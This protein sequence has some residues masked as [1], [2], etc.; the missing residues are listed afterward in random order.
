MR[1]YICDD[2]ETAPSIFNT[3]KPTKRVFRVDLYGNEV[4]TRCVPL[5]EEEREIFENRK[6]ST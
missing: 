1:C 3:H 4:C 5:S 6:K 2:C